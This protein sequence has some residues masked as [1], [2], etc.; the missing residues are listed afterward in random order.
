MYNLSGGGYGGSVLCDGMSNGCSTTGNAATTPVEVL[1]QYYPILV[2]HYRLRERSAG[3]GWRRG[4][5]GV[6]YRMRLL[7]GEAKLS[8]IMDHGRYGPQGALK[9]QDGAVN[10]VVVVHNDGTEYH[11]MHL[12]KDQG[13]VMTAG[14]TVEVWT[15]GGG[16]YGDPL[17]RSPEEV[18]RDVFLGYYTSEDAAEQYGVSVRASDGSIDAERTNE[19]RVRMRQYRPHS[20]SRPDLT[21]SACQFD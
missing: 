12:S 20:R 3:P 6:N 4:G 15:P 19:L 13:I 14:D 5:L 18:G 2:E 9:G 8:F 10:R 1:E 7:G 16:G 17:E 11:P 21:G